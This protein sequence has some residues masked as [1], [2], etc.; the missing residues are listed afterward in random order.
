MSASAFQN[1]HFAPFKREDVRNGQLFEA[2]RN[3]D[4]IDYSYIHVGSTEWNLFGSRPTSRNLFDLA[5]NID[6]SLVE[7]IN[8]VSIAGIIMRAKDGTT[9][10]STDVTR[11]FSPD[12]VPVSVGG[13]EAFEFWGR[14]V[15]TGTFRFASG[16]TAVGMVS[17]KTMITIS[18]TNGSANAI[19]T[20]PVLSGVYDGYSYESIE[21]DYFMNGMSWDVGY[22][23]LI[24]VRLKPNVTSRW[25]PEPSNDTAQF[26]TGHSFAHKD[27]PIRYLRANMTIPSLNDI[28]PFRG[29][30]DPDIGLLALRFGNDLGHIEIGTEHQV[31]SHF[32]I[33][34][35]SRSDEP[36]MVLD[37]QATVPAVL[38]IGEERHRFRA[39]I[40]TDARLYLADGRIAVFASLTP[41][42]GEEL[43]V[44]SI[45]Q[46]S[47]FFNQGVDTGYVL[48]IHHRHITVA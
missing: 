9:F 40:K 8:S 23:P 32:C 39:T 24:K 28:E 7:E 15:F 41:K 43:T 46:M 37:H 33:D 44:Y 26:F 27:G 48:N 12:F 22:L 13:A 36:I 42:S 35:K 30:I 5:R 19:V 34:P 20:D 18:K 47:K 6:P 45:D 4:G 11:N 38:V 2:T 17:L 25:T 14:T 21:R 1:L 10:E 16:D 29:G 31:G 3:V